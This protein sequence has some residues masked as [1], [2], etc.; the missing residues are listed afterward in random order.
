MDPQLHALAAGG[1]RFVRLARRE[2]RPL[3]AQWPA[4]ATDDLDTVAAWLRA[5]ANVGL[6]LGPATGIIDIETDT[7]EGLET[8]RAFGL[9]QI[10]TPIWRSSRGEHRLFVWHP[11]VPETAWRTVAGAEVRIGWRPAQSVLP[12]SVHPTGAAY[13]WLVPPTEAAVAD[14][15][16]RILAMLDGVHP[17]AW[18]R[19]VPPIATV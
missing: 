6:L 9:D 19:S 13:E 18:S 5:G 7:P 8:V 11:A 3:G 12:P 2:K 4:L 1:A 10:H 15:T 14:A 17:A 16:D